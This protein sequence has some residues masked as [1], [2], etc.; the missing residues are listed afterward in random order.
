MF[1]ES[2]NSSSSN[3]ISLTRDM[4][5]SSEPFVLQSLLKDAIDK[6]KTQ[7][8][9][10]L[11]E[12]QL[13]TLGTCD[14]VQFVAAVLEERVQAFHHFL[15]RDRHPKMKQSIRRTVHIL[16]TIFTSL[17]GA[18]QVGQGIGS[19]PFPPVKLVFAAIGVL[20]A[21]VKDVNGSYDALLQLFESIGN[22]VQRLDIY[23]KIPPTTVMTEILV[24]IIVELLST[25]ALA[26]KQIKQ[27]PLKIRNE[28]AR[29]E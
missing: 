10:S 29:R 16:H 15:G 2:T 17:G 23:T 9:T 19:I 11:I 7:V 12:S 20:L 4:S 1:S 22:F 28:A 26:T 13:T 6:Y 25:L 21:T 8:G 3:H 27:G 18:V 5:T 14:D 24:K